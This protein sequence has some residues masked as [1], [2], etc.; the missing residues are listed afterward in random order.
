MTPAGLVVNE[1][2]TQRQ[3]RRIHHSLQWSNMLKDAREGE[4]G[5]A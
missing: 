2:E 5:R 3:D 4:E 1:E